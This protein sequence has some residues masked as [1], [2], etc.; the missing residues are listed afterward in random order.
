MVLQNINENAALVQMQWECSFVMHW[1]NILYSVNATLNLFTQP[2]VLAGNPGQGSKRVNPADRPEECSILVLQGESEYFGG[3][4]QITFKTNTKE[5]N[6]LVPRNLG[7]SSD[8]EM[9]SKTFGA[10]MDHLELRMYAAK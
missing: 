8:Y 10:F 2:E 9:L 4:I 3:K 5:V 1:P 6:V 7:F